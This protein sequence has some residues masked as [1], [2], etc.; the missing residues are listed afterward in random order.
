[1]PMNA[2]RLEPQCKRLGYKDSLIEVAIYI[3][4]RAKP[5]SN[6]AYVT[7][8]ELRIKF[9][10]QRQSERFL[11]AARDDNLIDNI[12]CNPSNRFSEIIRFEILDGSERDP[13]GGLPLFDAAA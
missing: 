12:H 11:Q 7:T 8:W 10:D 6:I 13:L 4:S 5:G 3:D 2:L 1:M 9:K